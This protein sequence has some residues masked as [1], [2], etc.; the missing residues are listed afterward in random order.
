MDVEVFSLYQNEYFRMDR[1]H[2]N[3]PKHASYFGGTFVTFELI[4]Q[5]PSM[6]RKELSEIS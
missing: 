4:L 1:V 3:Y 2:R 5:P 6:P